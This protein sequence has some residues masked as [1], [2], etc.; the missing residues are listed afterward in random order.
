MDSDLISCINKSRQHILETM[1]NNGYDTTNYDNFTTS[2]VQAMSQYHQLDMIMTKPVDQSKI[3]VRFELDS[4]VSSAIINRLI[5]EL[6]Y[7]NSIVGE[8]GEEQE[9]ILK[10]TDILYVVLKTDPNETIINLLKQKWETDQIYIIPQSL[11]RL[12]FMVL[13]HVLVPPHRIMEQKEVEELMTL[14]HIKLEE[15]PRISRFDPAAQA[16]CIKPGQLCE[17]LRPSKTAI[18]DPFYRLCVNSEFAM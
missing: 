1:R 13:K 17:I 5:E 15:F 14:R 8:N 6:Y 11:R 3:Y 16:I 12:Q 2:E 10:K 18:V 9:P 7:G 4:K